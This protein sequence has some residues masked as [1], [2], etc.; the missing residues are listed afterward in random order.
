MLW[1]RAD[2]H[3]AFNNANYQAPAQ[4]V[5]AAGFGTISAAYPTRNIQ[6]GMKLMF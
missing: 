2:F 1:F 4:T 3:N 6:L 5:A